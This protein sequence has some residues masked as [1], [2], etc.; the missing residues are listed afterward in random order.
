M[1]ERS[2][3]AAHLGQRVGGHVQHTQPGQALHTLHLPLFRSLPV[4]RHASQ[5]QQPSLVVRTESDYSTD[6]PQTGLYSTAERLTS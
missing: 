1:S 2:Q 6:W 4:L 3:T 5:R